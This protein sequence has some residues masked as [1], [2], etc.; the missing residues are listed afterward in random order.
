MF[1]MKSNWH[2][3]RP[4]AGGSRRVKRLST[5]AL[6]DTVQTRCIPRHCNYAPKWRQCLYSSPIITS[7]SRTHIFITFAA[8]GNFP[9]PP[10]M[11]VSFYVEWKINISLAQIGTSELKAEYPFESPETKRPG[12]GLM[13]VWQKWQRKMHVSCKDC[14]KRGDKTS[15]LA[16]M[17]P[18][19]PL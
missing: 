5:V 16:F 10:Q 9:R 2:G 17:E 11:A 15:R 18:S 19:F 13:S 6:H 8:W 7:D 12:L 4:H 1:A 3:N 14:F